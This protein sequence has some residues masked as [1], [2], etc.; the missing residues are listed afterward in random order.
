[1]EVRVDREHP[2]LA[3]RTGHGVLVAVVDSGVAAGHPHLGSVSKGFSIDSAGAIGGDFDDRLGHG[4]AVAAAIQD[5]APAAEVLP[6]R[7]FGDRLATTA[8]ALAVAID[9]AVRAGAR[10]IN[11]SL[12]TDKLDH[13]AE[14]Q[15]C[16]DRALD[17]GALIVSPS[18]HRGRRWLPG[19]LAGCV[20]VDIDRTLDRH[21]MVWRSA[22]TECQCSASG[23]PRPIEGVPP[24]RNLKGISF[25]AA[26]T[27]GLLAL[28]LE[29]RE[30][31]D[32]ELLDRLFF[33]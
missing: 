2:A 5:K 7:V 27:T 22:R 12:G 28:A 32:R 9:E 11:L 16:V 8:R 30:C 26:N 10:L 33:L 21:A 24:E 23:E 15:A 6:V 13:Q 17:H 31:A 3:G 29:G 20:G 14:L 1:L 19:S 18:R 25:A 4:T